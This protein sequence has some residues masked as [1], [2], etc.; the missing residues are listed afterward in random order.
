VP[1]Q[2]RERLAE[3][4]EHYRELIKSLEDAL[5]RYKDDLRGMEDDA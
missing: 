5:E 1:D 3:E 2:Y 4:A